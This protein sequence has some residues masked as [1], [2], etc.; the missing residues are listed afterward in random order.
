MSS[1]EGPPDTTTTNI[2]CAS[3]AFRNLPVSARN[4]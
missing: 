4:I 2:F 3:A 1:Q